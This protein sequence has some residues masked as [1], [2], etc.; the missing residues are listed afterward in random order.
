MPKFL[1][2]IALGL[3]VAC[4]RKEESAPTPEAAVPDAFSAS[5]SADQATDPVALA[6]LA[7]TLDLELVDLEPLARQRGGPAGEAAGG[8]AGGRPESDTRPASAEQE[9]LL[10]GVRRG[11]PGGGR[12][13]IRS[14]GGRHHAARCGA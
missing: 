5:L 7:E 10:R 12:G 13:G 1:P 6:E 2:L 9:V 14:A 11:E 3:L 8:R 4:G